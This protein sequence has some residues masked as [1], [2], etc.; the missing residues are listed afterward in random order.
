M[1]GDQV[2]FFDRAFG[3][4]AHTSFETFIEYFLQS[5]GINHIE[6]QV[7]E[8]ALPIAPIPGHTR[9]VVDQCEALP[10]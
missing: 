3:L 10:N 5:G 6:G 1:R 4:L 8:L 2:G 9:L 7:E